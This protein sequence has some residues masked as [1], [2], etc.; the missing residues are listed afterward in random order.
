M[1]LTPDA[2]QNLFLRICCKK[3]KKHDNREKGLFEEEFKC[4]EMICPCNNIYCCYDATSDKYSIKG[5]NSV[6]KEK[7]SE[8]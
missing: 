8:H 2:V 3:H 7:I 4:K 1:I 5:Q 6:S